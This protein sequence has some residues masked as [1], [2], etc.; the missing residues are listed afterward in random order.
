MRLN[1]I[2]EIS[3]LSTPEKILLL[4]DLWDS[5]ATDESGVPVP[6]SHIEELDRRLSR[7]GSHLGDLLSLEDLQRGIAKRK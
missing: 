1:D 3:R 4:E 5:I 2:P 6:R 7:Y